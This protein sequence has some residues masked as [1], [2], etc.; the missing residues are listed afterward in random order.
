VAAAT[1]SG[2]NSQLRFALQHPVG[3]AFVSFLSGTIILWLI[4]LIDKSSLLPIHQW[5]SIAW[6]KWTGGALGAFFVTVII[7]TAQKVGVTNLFALIIAGQLTT[8][9]VY[10]HFGLLGFKPNPVTSTRLLG[11]LFLLLGAWLINKK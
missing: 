1:Q 7:L 8:A 9:L 3:A 6:Y 5:T 2:V 11:V 4:L 10:D